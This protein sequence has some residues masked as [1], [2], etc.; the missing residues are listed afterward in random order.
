M[1][2]TDELVDFVMKNIDK[3]LGFFENKVK[4]IELENRKFVL[5]DGRKID[6]QDVNRLIIIK[7]IVRPFSETPVTFIDMFIDIREKKDGEKK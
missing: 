3:I 1:K 5:E 6:F 7:Q 2:I 4:C